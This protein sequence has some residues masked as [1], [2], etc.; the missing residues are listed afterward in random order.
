VLGPGE[1]Q[2]LFH[3]TPLEQRNEQCRT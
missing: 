1:H 2:H 3:V